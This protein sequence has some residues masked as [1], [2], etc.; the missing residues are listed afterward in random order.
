MTGIRPGSIGVSRGC[1]L[2]QCLHWEDIEFLPSFSG[3]RKLTVRIHSRWLNGK[4]DGHK[5]AA[6][7]FKPLSFLIESPS[8]AC[9]LIADLPSLLLCT[10]LER[11]LFGKDKTVRDLLAD[12]SFRLQHD[13]I[14]TKPPVFLRAAGPNNQELHSSNPIYSSDLNAPLKA[15][16]REVGLQCRV[17][18]YAWRP[19]FLTTIARNASN[20]VAGQYADHTHD[21][22]RDSTLEDYYDYGPGDQ[23]ITALRLG[24]NLES[25][26]TLRNRMRELLDSSAIHRTSQYPSAE[27]DKYV[28]NHMASNDQ[29][30]A[31][32]MP[33]RS[34]STVFPEN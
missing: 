11:G 12:P 14:F 18:M 19:E 10:G 9:N 2:S 25:S 27:E 13:P 29:N 24:E 22:Q 21:D 17:S 15:A 26:G 28:S 8:Q 1:P 3:P 6:H 20:D 23:D 32:K 33:F 7:K 4:T 31:F 30:Q 5:S 34:S 16:C